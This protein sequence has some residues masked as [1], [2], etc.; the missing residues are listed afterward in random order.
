[1]RPRPTEPIRVTWPRFDVIEV[2]WQGETK[3]RYAVMDYLTKAARFGA[4]P[5]N[6]TLAEGLAADLHRGAHDA[7]E[8]TTVERWADAVEVRRPPKA[9]VEKQTSKGGAVR[10]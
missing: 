8:A 3:T 4:D 6:K 9:V 7:G 10:G 1:M 2:R 5:F